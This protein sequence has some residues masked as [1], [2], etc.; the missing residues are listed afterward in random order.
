MQIR[1]RMSP[2]IKEYQ[3]FLDFAFANAVGDFIPCHGWKYNNITFKTGD[4]VDTDLA[5]NRI[6]THYT[7]W[8]HH[9]EELSDK[10]NS[11]NNSMHDILGHF[12]GPNLERWG[13]EDFYDISFE[14][15]NANA[16]V[17]GGWR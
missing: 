16:N 11:D 5:V 17:V 15:P 3:N 8:S 9:G 7:K 4:E 10:S 2:S 13:A 12:G 1:D 14:K 6:I